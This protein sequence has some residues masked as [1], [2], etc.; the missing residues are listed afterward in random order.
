MGGLG[1][2]GVST[3]AYGFTEPVVRLGVT[4]YDL[5]PPRWPKGFQLRIAAIADLHA[6]D[7]WMSIDR[8]EGIVERTNALNADIIVLLGDYV[9]GH[10]HVTRFIAAD[11]WA[12]VLSGLKAPLGVHA[13]LG[14]HDWWEDQTGQRD[15]KGPTHARRALEVA[16]RFTKTMPTVLPRT[17]SR[18][19]S[20]A[21]AISWPICR[22]GASG[23]CAASASTTSARR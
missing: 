11:E 15:G 23:R 2:F 5:T 19:G 8:I 16:F 18:S 1:A 4:R 3:T 12:P 21:S 9:A 22:R 6:C 10:R 13:V 17:A 7:P 14:N 20:R